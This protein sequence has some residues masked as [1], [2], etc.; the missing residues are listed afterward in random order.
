ML[1]SIIKT[2]IMIN[3]FKQFRICILL[4]LLI[5]SGNLVMA[6]GTTS[7]SEFKISNKALKEYVGQYNFD[8]KAERGFDITISLD[9]DDRLMAQPTNKSQPLSLLAALEKDK[10]EI[11]NTD[12]LSVA[13]NRNDKGKI[14][15]L[16]F[17][18]GSLSFLAL[19]KN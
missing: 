15:S 1:I 8:P 12:G 16:E 6:Q 5:A 13:F 9:G 18:Q 3:L 2:Q 4:G 19:R 11:V 14:V 10:F 7:T 17:S